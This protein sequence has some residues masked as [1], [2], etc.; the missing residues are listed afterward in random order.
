MSSD[1][2]DKTHPPP[3]RL[4]STPDT[5]RKRRRLGSSLDP[6]QR[7]KHDLLRR[8]D[9]E[10]S[11]NDA[12]R[13]LFNEHV[14]QV[15]ARFDV[16]T[17]VQHYTK[18]VGSALWQSSEQAMFFAAMERLGRDDAAGIARAIGTKTEAETRDFL[19]LLHD[20]AA[21]QGDAKLTLRDIP[22]ACEIGHA[23]SQQLDRAAD[24]LA[25]YQERLEAAHEQ[26]RHGDYWLITP[27]IANDIEAAVQSL[28]PA[29]AASEA[30]EAGPQGMG[31]GVAG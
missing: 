19:V 24:S 7:R 16:D 11:Y 29:R 6:A 8:Q 30:H 15:A 20:A 31:P 13:L 28:R 1:D 21:N 5:P 25:W 12:Y 22:A 23:C 14:A 18:Q 26:E 17:A 4:S 3:R 9:V 2:G 10:A 27:S